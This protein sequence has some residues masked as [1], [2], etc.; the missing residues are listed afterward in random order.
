MSNNM[1]VFYTS[2][3]PLRA[4]L[5]TVLLAIFITLLIFRLMANLLG[6]EPAPPPPLPPPMAVE[7]FEPRADTAVHPKVLLTP[8]APPVE[9]PARQEFEI[10]DD[11]YLTEAGLPEA[12]PD[13]AIS[14]QQGQYLRETDFDARP[15]VRVE[16]QY[17]AVAAREGI[18][19]W[20]Q[21]SFS[22]DATGAVTDIVVLDAEPKRVFEQAAVRALKRWKYQ[23]ST[24]GGVAYK[25]TGL[26]VQ[27]DFSLEQ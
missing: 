21:L 4:R 24:E 20:V 18:S 5:G 19:G 11:P 15:L 2:Q 7:L 1:S 17:P 9:P 8:P 14:Q 26:T 23:P 13:I 6:T 3:T 27:L 22:I 10:S 25:Q 16:P 12:I